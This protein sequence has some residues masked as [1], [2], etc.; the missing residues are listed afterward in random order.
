MFTFMSSNLM[1]TCKLKGFSSDCNAIQLHLL[2][3][4]CI[5]KEKLH[6]FYLPSSSTIF[7]LTK[8]I[9]SDMMD[10]VKNVVSIRNVYN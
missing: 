4:E 7:L 2:Q 6:Y 8:P 9:F 5:N 10:S 1:Y 3:I